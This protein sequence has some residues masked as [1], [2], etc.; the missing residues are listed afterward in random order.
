MIIRATTIDY[1]A[2]I[3]TETRAVKIWQR[4][5]EWVGDGTWYADGNKLIDC[6]ADIGEPACA[7][8]DEAIVAALETAGVFL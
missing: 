1:A 2:D 4:D 6:E 5:G 8:I 7:A 3:D